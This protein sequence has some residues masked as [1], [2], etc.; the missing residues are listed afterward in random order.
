MSILDPYIGIVKAVAC[1]GS[2]LG[3]VWVG[4][5]FTAQADDI[6]LEQARAET[7]AAVADKERTM[8]ARIDAITAQSKKDKQDAQDKIDAVIASYR[9]GTNR[10][11]VDVANCTPASA[12]PGVTDQQAR[13][14]LLPETSARLVELARDANDSVRDLNECID[15][16]N[17]VKQELDPQ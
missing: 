17:A 7:V 9:N 5:H 1:V 15:K 11:R 4:H 8:Q 14:E 6:K 16:Y 12:D 3:C 2:L 10:V 13:A